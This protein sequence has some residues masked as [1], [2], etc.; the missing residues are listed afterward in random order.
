MTGHCKR[1]QQSRSVAERSVCSDLEAKGK[2]VLCP[3]E[4]AG[5]KSAPAHVVL[6]GLYPGLR[7]GAGSQTLRGH[8]GSRQL[9]ARNTALMVQ[10]PRSPALHQICP[11]HSRRVYNLLRPVLYCR[12]T[13]HPLQMSLSRCLHQGSRYSRTQCRRALTLYNPV[14]T[15]CCAS[16]RA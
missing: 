5:Q 2:Q 11:I 13:C 1:Q 8:R 7:L 4:V 3:F 15:C 14:S 6:R 9:P 10:P 12:K 16:Y